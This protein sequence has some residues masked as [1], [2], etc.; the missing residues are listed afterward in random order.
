MDSL[1]R[2]C[3]DYGRSRP[4]HLL[5][6]HPRRFL[7]EP[8]LNDPGYIVSSGADTRPGWLPRSDQRHGLHRIV[9]NIG[10]RTWKR[11]N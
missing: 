9:R 5:S 6:A 8:V 3:A 4:E 10:S 1:R 2:T 11:V 7:I